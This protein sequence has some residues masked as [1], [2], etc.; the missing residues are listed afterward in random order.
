MK[1]A[2]YPVTIIAIL[3]FIYFFINSNTGKATTSLVRIFEPAS[4]MKLVKD[5]NFKGD[6]YKIIA[7]KDSL[8]IIASP[9]AVFICDSTFSGYRQVKD[10]KNE[11]PLYHFSANRDSVFYFDVEGSQFTVKAPGFFSRYK[12]SAGLNA[13]QA[14]YHHGAFIYSLYSKMTDS[15]SIYRYDPVNRQNTLLVQVNTLLKDKITQGP[16]TGSALEGNFLSIDE[17]KWCY[18][19]FMG[20]YF[21]IYDNGHISLHQTVDKRPFKKFQERQVKMGTQTVFMCKGDNDY[22]YNYQA[23]S[24]GRFLYILSGIIQQKSSEPLS[25]PVD[26]YD[27]SNF[28]YISTL[29]LPLLSPQDYAYQLAVLRDYFYV[30]SAKS[31][32]K[33]YRKQNLD[34]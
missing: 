6:I 3:I 10:L 26:V 22:F 4:T 23:A 1:R 27:L 33:I 20:G 21:I 13:G 15:I 30:Y 18:L 5:V 2:I 17:N 14:F 12:T 34:Q 24:D 32:L 31:G 11:G 16:C 8:A 9:N 19:L 7:A 28:R 25:T 29:K